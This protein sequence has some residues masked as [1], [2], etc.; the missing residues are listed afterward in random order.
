MGQETRNKGHGIRDQEQGTWDKRPGTRDM[1]Y[2]TRNKGYGT[3][4]QE[5]GIMAVSHHCR[6][7]SC[8]VFEH[9]ANGEMPC[10]GVSHTPSWDRRSSCSPVLCFCNQIYRI[11]QSRRDDIIVVNIN[12][13][14]TKPRRG[15]IIFDEPIQKKPLPA[16]IQ[17]RAF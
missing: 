13:S 1:G 2:E 9:T 6:D 3:R 17:T 11:Q 15:G 5:Q 12:Q 16:I 4:N 14:T 10:T 7:V 8:N